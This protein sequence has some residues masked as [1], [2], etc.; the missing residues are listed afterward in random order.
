MSDHPI[1]GDS[2]ATSD[3]TVQTRAVAPCGSGDATELAPSLDSILEQVVTLR[4][5][6]A[7][8]NARSLP[9]APAE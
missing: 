3:V 6:A 4:T 7:Y 5:L 1:A 9:I 2:G 8:L